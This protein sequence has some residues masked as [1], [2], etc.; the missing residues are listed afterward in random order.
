MQEIISE[1]KKK[2]D[3]IFFSILLFQ[4]IITQKIHS[5]W[6]KY[7]GGMKI[8]KNCIHYYDK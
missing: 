1:K 6:N 7:V 2:K 5:L 3:G 8:F 4:F